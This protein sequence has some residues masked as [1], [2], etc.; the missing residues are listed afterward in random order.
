MKLA[1]YEWEYNLN[2][3]RLE[4]WVADYPSWGAGGETE[5]FWQPGPLKDAGP[6]WTP[7]TDVDMPLVSTKVVLMG[8]R[9]NPMSGNVASFAPTTP[10]PWAGVFNSNLQN[11]RISNLFMEG[12]AVF[13]NADMYNA[14]KYSNSVDSH[15]SFPE[16]S[17]T[18]KINL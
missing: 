11:A 12:T 7:G 2:S 17:L 6:V 8:G 16:G 3:Y 10:Q 1:V 15:I 5:I 13:S 4:V 14:L 9:D 18:A